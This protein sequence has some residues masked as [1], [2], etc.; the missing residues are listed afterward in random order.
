MEEE[1]GKLIEYE[2]VVNQRSIASLVKQFGNSPYI[3]NKYLRSKGV[4]VL[5]QQNQTLGTAEEYIQYYKQGYSLEKIGKMFKTR[6]ERISKILKANG[7]QIINRQNERGTQHNLFSTIDTDE[8][9]YWLGFL[10]ADG[11]IHSTTNAIE[12]GLKISDMNHL[13]KFKQFIKADNKI[14]LTK[15]GKA[16]RYCFYSKQM[17]LD[18]ISLGCTPKKS[19]TL[20]FPSENQLP[21]E[22]QLAF[23][24]GYFDGD[25]CFTFTHTTSG[26][27]P[28]VKFLGTKDVLQGINKVLNYRER[29]YL[30]ANS[31]ETA[32]H[33]VFE[34]SYSC[35]DSIDILKKLYETSSL[36]LDR[37]YNRYQLFK[38]FGF[39]VQDRNILDY[40]GAKSVKAQSEVLIPS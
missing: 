15:D 23:V 1:L 3:I 11:A 6:P 19:E 22:H 5:N 8:K 18:L 17:R 20:L 25:G 38:N 35:P 4:C 24:R 2:Y 34:T 37:K 10:Y 7:I 14:Y 28:I 30:L 13:L 26:Y 31:E 9:A 21:K 27:K 12:L 36:H 33:F 32:S 16:A 29:N 39:A 40:E